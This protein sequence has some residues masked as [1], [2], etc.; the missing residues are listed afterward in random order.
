MNDNLKI[1]IDFILVAVG[2]FLGF[3]GAL[4]SANIL[5]NKEQKKRYEDNRANI[6]QELFENMNFMDEINKRESGTDDT[7][8]FISPYVDFYWES[9]IY[10]DSINLIGKDRKFS[11][12]VYAYRLIDELN[13]FEN[14]KQ[15]IFLQH[16]KSEQLTNIK[17]ILFDKRNEYISYIQKEF[18]DI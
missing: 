2:G 7:L 16:G 6:L 11:A 15:G 13:G 5:H 14:L 9:L 3:A 4:L 12:I 17:A 10:T 8:F 18:I 1:F